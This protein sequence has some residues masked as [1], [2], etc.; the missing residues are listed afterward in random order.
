MAEGEVLLAHHFK[1]EEVLDVLARDLV[2][3]ARPDIVRSE[4]IEGL[5]VLLLLH[6]VEAGDDLLRGLLPGIDD[7]LRCLEAF[8]EGRVIQH[9]VVLLE[10]RQHR[11]ARC[12]RPA[13]HNGRDLVVD[14]E[15]LGFLGEGRPV[16]GAVLLDELDLAA[17][18]AAL[19]IDLIDGKL[20]GLNR[21][22]LA[23]RHGAGNR[24]QDADG[25]LGIGDCQSGRV[26]LR[27]RKLLRERRWR[28]H[29]A[30]R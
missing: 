30:R 23:D 2:G 1:L 24:M 10:H 22:G 20:L 6:P 8:V 18:H 17:E 3:R 26:D 11:L 28:K 7:V 19:R 25:N 5:C 9:P 27:R 29:R 4:E 14:E 21:A 16:A 12:R 13:A 15:F